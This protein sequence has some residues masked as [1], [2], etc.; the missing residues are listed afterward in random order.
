MTVHFLCSP[1]ENEPKE[2]ASFP[3]EFLG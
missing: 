1:K 2:K 3:H